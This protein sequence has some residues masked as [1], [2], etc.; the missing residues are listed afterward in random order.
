MPVKT[1]IIDISSLKENPDNP[2]K[3]TDA[4]FEA[5]VQSVKQFPQMLEIRPVIANKGLMVLGGNMRLRACKEAGLKQVPVQI[6]DLTPEQER[7]FIIKDNVGYGIW[8]WEMIGADWPE[9][10]EWGLDMPEWNDG[11]DTSENIDLKQF[12]DSAEK[13]INS[14]VRQILLTFDNDTH[15]K[16]M[17]RLLSV[18]KENNIDSDNSAAVLALLDF[19]ESN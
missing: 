5:L 14:T 18:Q 9:A 19:Y 3:L 1:T 11:I 6:V 10:A 17:A 4:K 7:E 13:Y 8:N 12:N 15:T 2:R 16:T